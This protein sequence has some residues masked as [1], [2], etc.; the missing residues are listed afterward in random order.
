V[1]RVQF[2]RFYILY[3]SCIYSGKQ[4][5]CD[6]YRLG[7]FTFCTIH[8]FSAVE[9]SCERC[10]GQEIL[11]FVLFMHDLSTAENT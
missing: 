3:C 1:R 8:V 2:G 7:D 9:I 6:M 10:T 5:M 4:I 11:H